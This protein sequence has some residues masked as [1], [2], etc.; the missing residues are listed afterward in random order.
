MRFT[1]GFFIAAA[2]ST[3]VVLPACS[4]EKGADCQK[5]VQ[6]TGPAHSA[7]KDAFGRS[8]QLPADLEAQAEAW[9]KT[10]AELKALALKDSS[11]QAIATEYAG[12]LETAAKIRRDMA[13]A[14]TALDP[15]AAAKSQA[16]AAGFI[17]DEMKAMSKIQTTCN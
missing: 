8:D 4:K 11:I 2:A 13:A 10:A 15:T 14:G 16:A 5:L 17:T 6:M 1:V 12:V 9:E 3:C 7:V